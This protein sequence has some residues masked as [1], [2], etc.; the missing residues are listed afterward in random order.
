MTDGGRSALAR[1]AVADQRR[2]SRRD[3]R[4]VYPRLPNGMILPYGAAG[5]ARYL[6]T[7]GPLR[8]L[9]SVMHLP[10]AMHRCGGYRGFRSCR[11]ELKP[12]FQTATSLYCSPGLDWCAWRPR[13]IA[14]AVAGQSAMPNSDAAA[15]LPRSNTWTGGICLRQQALTT[16]FSPASRRSR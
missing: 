6:Q 11:C 13:R 8:C 2:K 12:A 16:R 14:R 15:A 1:A 10:S 3:E 9:S 4:I 7:H 5:S